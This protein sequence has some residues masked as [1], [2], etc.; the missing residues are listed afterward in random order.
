MFSIPRE[1][2]AALCG[3][4]AWSLSLSGK[5]SRPLD[6]TSTLI[7]V[8][9]DETMWAAVMRGDFDSGLLMRGYA[10]VVRLRIHLNTLLG[11]CDIE[12]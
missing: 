7:G 6:G 2:G 10:V 1:I 3:N 4:P 8:P 11:I 5:P 9:A 12:R